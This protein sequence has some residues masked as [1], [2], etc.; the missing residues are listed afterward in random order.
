MGVCGACGPPTSTSTT[1]SVPVEPCDEGGLVWEAIAEGNSCG[2]RIQ[3][4]L[5]N[6]HV[7]DLLA[8]KAMVAGEYPAICGAC[9]PD[10]PSTTED[11]RDPI[12]P[13]DEGGSVWEAIAEGNSCGSRIQWVSQNVHIGDLLAS[14]AM[15]AGEYPAICGACGPPTS[16]S[17]TVSVPVE[18]CDEGGSVWNAI[19]EDHSCGSRIQWLFENSFQNWDQAKARV[20]SEY[21]SVCGACARR[22]LLDSLP[23]QQG[24]VA[25]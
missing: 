13:C 2:S 14:K 7:G 1:V 10:S 24:Y 22:R 12:D 6:V 20:A 25:V 11:P 5:Q 16:T 3:W 15:V 17:T 4:V 8:S 19:A 21:P 9:G 23:I 18:P